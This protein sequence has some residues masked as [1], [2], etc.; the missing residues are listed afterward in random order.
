MSSTVTRAVPLIYKPNIKKNH[1]YRLEEEQ[2]HYQEK[3]YKLTL[4]RANNNQSRQ[5]FNQDQLSLE[6]YDRDCNK[7]LQQ[8][9]QLLK[10]P[11]PRKWLITI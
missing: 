1:I 5:L 7:L 8:K 9:H 11:K 2:E 3:L 6:Q 4:V 10:Q